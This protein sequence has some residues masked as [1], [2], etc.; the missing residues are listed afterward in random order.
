LAKFDN[1]GSIVTTFGTNGVWTN[2]SNFGQYFDIDYNNDQLI[3]SG[4]N[5]DGFTDFM[6]ESRAESDA[7]LNANFGVNGQTIIDLNPSDTYYEVIFQTDGKI[8]A[9]GTTGSAGIGAARDF[10]VS[11][12]N[13]NGQLIPLGAQMATH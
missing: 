9:C 6:L 2:T 4:N 7:N 3:I 10:I 8:L 13:S 11:R 1:T 12:F 5:G